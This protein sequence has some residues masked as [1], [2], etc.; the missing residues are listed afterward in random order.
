VKTPALPAGF[1]LAT[2]LLSPLV[3]HPADVT[4]PRT[5]VRFAERENGMALLGAGVRT[6]TFLKV[7]VYAIGL[8]VADSALAGPLAKYRGRPTD[9]A[10]YRELVTGDFPK[11]VVMKFVRTT[12]AA[13]VRAAFYEA[14]PS[15]DRQR[16]DLFASH[17]GAPRNGDVYVVRWAPGGVLEV[18]AAGQAKQPIADKAFATAVFGIWLGEKPLQED[19][20]RDLVARAAQVLK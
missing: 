17:F 10:F 14:L 13:Q 6:R 20:K 4:E 12:T 18:T 15:E 8:Y 11:Q 2:V 1:A 5:G 19:I 9:P 7:K 16:L 3:A